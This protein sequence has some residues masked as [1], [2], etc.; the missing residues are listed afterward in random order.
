MSAK[1]KKETTWFLRIKSGTVFGPVSLPGLVAWAEQGQVKAGNFISS[2]RQNWRL[3]ESIPE[4]AL[5]WYLEDA[6]GETI[7]P[8][9]KSVAQ[10]IID[11]GRIPEGTKMVHAD[12][13]DLSR[14]R[15]LPDQHDTP[16]LP[17]PT[18]QQELP[19][20]DADDDTAAAATAELEELRAK[21]EELH[22]ECEELRQ[23]SA[24]L[25]EQNHIL[26]ASAAK[27]KKNCTRQIADAAKNEEKLK[28]RIVDLVGQIAENATEA[29]DS[30]RLREQRDDFEKRLIEARDS[31]VELLDYSNQ[32]DSET[33]AEIARLS[34]QCQEL[35]DQL[36]SLSKPHHEQ[37]LREF[38]A[39]L[40]DQETLLAGTL[41]EE[42]LALS[43][44][45]E[46]E[47]ASFST[48]RD[49]SVARQQLIQ[50]RLDAIIKLQGGDTKD[51]FE[52]EARE[53][54]AK[55][56]A[57]RDREDLKALES[58]FDKLQRQ[59]AIREQELSNR[60]RMLEIEGDRL[61]EQA[62]EAHLLTSEN[63]R[64]SEQLSDREQ[65]LAQERQERS[66]EQ[67]QL[68]QAHQAL[69]E[70]LE[71]EKNNSSSLALT[72]EPDNTPKPEKTFK[73]TPWM[74]FKK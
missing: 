46:S 43:E 70:Q 44:V 68:E 13:A 48:L 10:K 31:Y 20:D 1:I 2:D 67:A 42:R 36:D 33:T 32:R 35:Q 7:G 17:Q 61:R 72:E 45:L 9:N 37:S 16:N 6:G 26:V 49:A 8:F 62:S 23:R 60:I 74:Q 3:A 59:A 53:R 63:Q 51:T 28:E 19:L 58:E 47:R 24:Q 54:H 21:C 27:E 64:L 52:R 40:Q 14:L 11:E 66:I 15:P 69:I 41:N 57:A 4:L 71:A 39:R 18:E 30:E 55:A 25:E 5:E 73:A 50:G 22:A 29:E 56:Q 34:Q 12:E 38:N 65:L